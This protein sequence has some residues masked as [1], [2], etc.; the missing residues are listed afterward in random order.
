[1][2]GNVRASPPGTS[3][4]VRRPAPGDLWGWEMTTSGNVGS[5]I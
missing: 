4:M 2:S 1:V 3:A 5:R